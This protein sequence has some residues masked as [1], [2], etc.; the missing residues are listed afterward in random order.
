MDQTAGIHIITWTA[1]I[2]NLQKFIT[3]IKS[4]KQRYF[5]NKLFGFWSDNIIIV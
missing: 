4:N 1:N 3:L 2:W 5:E